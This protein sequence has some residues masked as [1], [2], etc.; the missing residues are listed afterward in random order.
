MSH[1]FTPLRRQRACL[2][3]SPN[4]RSN[5]LRTSLWGAHA[6]SSVFGVKP[7]MALTAAAR[8]LPSDAYLSAN[9]TCE[10]SLRHA[11]GRLYESFIS[12]LE[13]LSRP[14]AG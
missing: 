12:P 8:S 4:R 2:S 11:T 7:L 9:R 10:M 14:K 5:P 13:E 1:L 3:G 6:F